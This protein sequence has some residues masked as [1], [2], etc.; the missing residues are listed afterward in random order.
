MGKVIVQAS[1]SLD[2]FI[3]DTNDQVGPLF[4]WFDNGDVEF[5]GSDSS[6]VFHISRASADYLRAA[7]SNIAV[8]VIGRRLFDLT[9]GWNGR[10]AVGEAVFVVTHEPP[11][12]WPFPDAPFSFVTDGVQSAV[13][14][15]QAFAGDKD[16]SLTAGNLVGQALRAGLVD[17]L[18]ID[19][20]PVVFGSGVRYFGNYDES[21]LLLEDPEIVQGD[22]VTHLHYRIRK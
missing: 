2:G 17:E 8:D 16:V 14:Q 7:W 5:S 12:D 22:R 3:A 9:N 21:T 6:M 10:P 18:R 1:M 19:L 4:D 20:V 13:A 11:T 15:A